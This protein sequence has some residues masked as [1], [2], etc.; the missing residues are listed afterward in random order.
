MCGYNHKDFGMVNENI[1]NCF[2]NL[3]KI[4]GWSKCCN[5]TDCVFNPNDD[6]LDLKRAFHISN[7][8]KII[9]YR[10]KSFWNSRDYGSVITDNAIYVKTEREAKQI[11]IFKWKDI[12]KVTYQNGVLFIWEE[13]CQS[14]KDCGYIGM[15]FFAKGDEYI[16]NSILGQQLAKLFSRVAST[17]NIEEKKA[18][19]SQ[20]I[21]SEITLDYRNWYGINERDSILT[22]FPKEITENFY[23][24]PN[25]KLLYFRDTSW[26]NKNQGL[27]LT[28]WGMHI[29]EDNN[30]PDNQVYVSW[31][32]L[33][34]V[35]YNNNRFLCY[36]FGHKRTFV[37]PCKYLIK[38]F[39]NCE[40]QE[41]KCA[42]S[43]LLNL[44]QSMIDSRPCVKSID[45]NVIENQSQYV[46]AKDILHFSPSLITRLGAKEILNN[47]ASAEFADFI[48]ELDR[49][50]QLE[51]NISERLCG[52]KQK[53]EQCV[54]N[55]HI[56][57]QN[58]LR[59]NIQQR[60]RLLPRTK[61]EFAQDGVA[62]FFRVLA[63][64]HA[65]N[66]KKR[67]EQKIKVYEAGMDRFLSSWINDQ[68]NYVAV[69][70]DTMTTSLQKFSTMYE[71]TMTQMIIKD[72]TLNTRILTAQCC[73][74][75][76]CR[77]LQ[78]QQ[79]ARA[80]MVAM[81][82]TKNKRGGTSSPVFLSL[83]NI[84]KSELNKLPQLLFGDCNTAI[85]QWQD[86]LA[87]EDN[88]IIPLCL[89]MVNQKNQ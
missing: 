49:F 76:Y 66:E 5:D 10:D 23:I 74:A 75:L 45:A 29:I 69:Q 1:Y 32:D 51:Q 12:K 9:F 14:Q 80:I 27:V 37:V 55:V 33:E 6:I 25:E 81:M 83:E 46:V 19:T 17:E 56:Q 2:K 16:E 89:A 48:K 61:G 71:H 58:V 24:L 68:I 57:C 52:H 54:Q 53:I 28:D 65:E 87:E 73:F 22:N 8:E 70:I 40:P 35:R 39:D 43:Y 15:A 44:L 64:V 67:I 3:Y 20:E 36:Y 42:I 34:N 13:D 88:S 4:S 72:S 31:Q 11:L 78:S 47:E 41:K 30:N 77:M 82:Q 50:E 60:N 84:I 63:D 59:N 38:G 86:I 85:K 62:I 18:K 21:F 79:R 7:Q 26:N